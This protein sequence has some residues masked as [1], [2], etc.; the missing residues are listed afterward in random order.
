[1]T[2]LLERVGEL[3]ALRAAVAA[4]GEG[5]GSVVLVAGEAGIGKSTLVQAWAADP[6]SDARTLIGWCD[7]FLTSRAL[8]PLHDVARRT[9]GPLA[10]AIAAEDVGEVLDALLAELAYPLAPTVILIEDLHWAD[11][12]TLDVIRYVGRRIRDLPAVLALTYRDDEIS[13]DHP[14]TGV[15]G[16]LP[17]A[18]VHRLVPRHLSRSAVATLTAGTGLDPDEVVRLTAGNPFFV[19]ELAATGPAHLATTDWTVPPSIGD[20]VLARLCK[21]P[22]AARRAVETLSVVPGSI[23]EDL[24]DVLVADRGHLAAAERAGVLLADD[25]IMRFR[26]ELAR[27][28]VLASI[29]ATTQISHHR[30]VLYHLLATGAD[31]ARILH[32]AVGATRPDIIATHGPQAAATAFRTGAHREAVAHGERVLAHPELL[33]HDVL[34]RLLEE[35]SWALYHLQRL[36]DAA[37]VMERATFVNG[38]RGDERSYVRTLL[39]LARMRYLMDGPAAAEHA[40]IEAEEVLAAFEDP[41][42]RAELDTWRLLLLAFCGRHREVVT[43]SQH[44]LACARGL[45]RFDLLVDALAHTGLSMVALGDEQGIGLIEDAIRIGREHGEQEPVARS[46]GALVE[47]HLL[48][49]RWADAR[50]SIDEAVMFYDH[51]DY[52]ARHAGATPP[53]PGHRFDTLA[54]RAR[55]EVEVGDWQ[56]SKGVLQDLDAAILDAG[57]MG[58]AALQVHALLAV[59]A[60]EESAETLLRRAWET[61]LDAGSPSHVVSVACAGVEWAWAAERPEAADE[62]I[63]R[64]KEEADGSLLLD[65]LRWRLSLVGH[66]VDAAGVSA[67]PERTSLAGDWRSAAHGWEELGMPFERALELLHADQQEPVLEALRLFER[68]GA[69]PAARMARKRLR[70]LGMRS[71]PRGATT[72]TRQSPLGLTPRQDE[73]FALIAE[74]LTNAEIAERLVVSVRTVDH[75]V[76]TVLS[77][78]GVASRRQAANVAAAMRPE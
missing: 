37:T 14:L 46:Y 57:L 40:L 66:P 63:A 74:G 70:E 31:P 35:H 73:V 69:D 54:Q 50:R 77:K 36:A 21:L 52:R 42:I 65:P 25:A 12:A 68:L 20:A 58:V 48:H 56:G 55:M 27:Q 10:E 30:T 15:L 41:G 67:E 29:P 4:A 51:H 3:A 32:H 76:S 26:H 59:R 38:E 45:D 39:G 43:A 62:F 22:I 5:R 34:A 18:A 78:L 7:D 44:V 75:H 28:A 33:T 64:A 71:V 23:D 49:R 17:A 24:L 61:A 1:M 2:D 6:G 19:T 11:D 9:S 13:P 16:T 8:G 47:C 72:A 60:G 53:C